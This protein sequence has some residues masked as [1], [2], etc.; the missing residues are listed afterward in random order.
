MISL[1]SNVSDG[2][3]ANASPAWVIRL[4]LDSDVLLWSSIPF[5][6]VDENVPVVGKYPLSGGLSEISQSIDISEGGNLAA[7]G[8]CSLAVNEFANASGTHTEYLPQVGGTELLNRVVQIGIAYPASGN[9]SL[10]TDVV[11]LYSGVVSDYNSNR[12]TLSLDVIGETNKKG[13]KKDRE[14][15][16]RVGGANN[17]R[18]NGK[19]AKYYR[20]SWAVGY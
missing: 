11:W 8:N 5:Q 15:V 2:L 17:A 12:T 10:A 4:I 13:V 16:K 14:S 1:S 3:N 18:T 20:I 7:V 9:V 6:E 19:R